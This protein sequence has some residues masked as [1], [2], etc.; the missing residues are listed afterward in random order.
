MGTCFFFVA[1]G[2]PHVPINVPAGYTLPGNGLKQCV[3]TTV[4]RADEAPV[5]RA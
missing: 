1:A 3:W 4:E 2:K 5:R